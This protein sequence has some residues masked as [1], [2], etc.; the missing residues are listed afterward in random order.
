MHN[1][2]QKLYLHKHHSLI[3]GTYHQ[4]PPHPAALDT[5]HWYGIIRDYYCR[6]IKTD[7]GPFVRLVNYKQ[8]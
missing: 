2:L 3:T 7:P 1:S 8:Q 4:F 5:D 6:Y